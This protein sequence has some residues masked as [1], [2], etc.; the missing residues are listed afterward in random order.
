MND[1]SCFFPLDLQYIPFERLIKFSTFSAQVFLSLASFIQIS[2]SQESYPSNFNVCTYACLILCLG[3]P[4]E[5]FLS[6]YGNQEPI[7][8]RGIL[9]P[10]ILDIFSDHILLLSSRY[11]FSGSIPICLK[12]F[13]FIANSSTY[14]RKI[15]DSE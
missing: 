12:I 6:T 14:V 8:L 11:V 1:V 9:S 13:L 4:E 7:N 2:N 10:G 5:L 3:L 15:N